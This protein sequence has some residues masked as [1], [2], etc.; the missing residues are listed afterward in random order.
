MALEPINSIMTM[1]AQTVQPASNNAK[2]AME[3]T[4]VSIAENAPK[5]DATTKVV[6][7]ASEKDSDYNREEQ[8]TPSKERIHKAV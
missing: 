7:N 5:V 4:D 3:Y 1:Q 2:T 6:E 8:Q